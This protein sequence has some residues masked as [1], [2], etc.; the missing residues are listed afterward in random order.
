MFSFVAP[1]SA[2]TPSPSDFCDQVVLGSPAPPSSGCVAGRSRNCFA[3][4]T[5]ERPS[6]FSTSRAVLSHRLCF[7]PLCTVPPDHFSF[8]I[9]RCVSSLGLDYRAP[10]PAHQYVSISLLASGKRT[11]FFF[12]IFFLPPVGCRSSHVLLRGTIVDGTYAIHE[13]LYI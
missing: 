8:R 2:R 11:S 12:F 6:L 9:T 3:S 7:L 10:S 13:N 5:I 4:S 1:A